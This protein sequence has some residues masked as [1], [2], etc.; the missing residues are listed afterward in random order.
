VFVVGVPSPFGRQQVEVKWVD[1]DPQFDQTPQWAPVRHGPESF[2]PERVKLALPGQ[3]RQEEPLDSGFGPFAL[4]RLAVETSGIYFSVHSN[5]N[6]DRPVRR[7]ETS[8]LSSYIKYFFEPEVMR[9][10]RPDYVSAAEYRNLLK[11][12]AAKRA[13]VRAAA[14]SW[15]QPMKEPRTKFP[16]RN[17]AA[18]VGLLG[19]AQQD[20]AKILAG[21]LMR[22][23]VELKRGEKDRDKI[24][25]PRWQAGYDLAMGRTLA[26][27]VRAQ[28][29]NLMLAR[30]RRGMKFQDPASD[31]WL[32]RPS[33]EILSG[34]AMEKEA[35]KA[36]AYLQRVVEEHEGTPWAMIASRELASPL[37]WKWTEI[38]TNVNPPPQPPRPQNNVRPLP[39]DDT[40]V[41]IERKQKRSPPRL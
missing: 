17:E 37:G 9:R 33:R 25:R 22:M 23:V 7:G 34:T 5:R 19:E 26:A 29:Y 12:N 1:P 16:K 15:T 3:T 21:T 31:T 28:G 35:G 27:K 38:F 11:K 14:F 41:F 32:I 36:V 40:R 24:R 6:S 20:S 2:L 10:Y 13:L 30:A 39:R 4:T 18:L 8:H